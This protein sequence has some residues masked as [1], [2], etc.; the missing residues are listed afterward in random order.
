MIFFF[1]EKCRKLIISYCFKNNFEKYIKMIFEKNC[2]KVLLGIY[3]ELDYKFN[4]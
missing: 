3:V 1:E 4:L 2:L